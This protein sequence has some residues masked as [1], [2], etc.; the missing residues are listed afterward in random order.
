MPFYQLFGGR[1]PLLKSTT[2]K[3][4]YPYSNL[5]NLEDLVTH[6]FHV[7]SVPPPVPLEDGHYVSSGRCRRLCGPPPTVPQASPKAAAGSAEGWLAGGSL[8]PGGSGFLGV[9]GS[10]ELGG[11]KWACPWCCVEVA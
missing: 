1:V 9:S 8:G 7:H 11:A 2:E 6:A 4:W 5:A 3:S 10:S